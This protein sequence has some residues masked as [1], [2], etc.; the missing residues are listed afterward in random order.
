MTRIEFI[1]GN[2]GP[3]VR[4]V[5]RLQGGVLDLLLEQGSVTSTLDLTRVSEL[6]AAAK[7]TLVHRI[8]DRSRPVICPG[9]LALWVER[10]RARQ[11]AEDAAC[12]RPSLPVPEP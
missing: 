1:P 4:V 8:P 3:E 5:G 12:E 11:V 2:D 6:D 10:E 7:H 9:W